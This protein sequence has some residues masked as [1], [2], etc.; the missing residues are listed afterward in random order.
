[1]TRRRRSSVRLGQLVSER[2]HRTTMSKPRQ[3]QHWRPPPISRTSLCPPESNNTIWD[4]VRGLPRCLLTLSHFTVTPVADGAALCSADWFDRQQA[5][6]EAIAALPLNAPLHVKGVARGFDHGRGMLDEVSISFTLTLQV[7]A[8]EVR[9]R[10]IAAS[11]TAVPQLGQVHD[12]SA[13]LSTSF[14]LLSNLAIPL[15]ATLTMTDGRQRETADRLRPQELDRGEAVIV[16]EAAADFTLLSPSPLHLFD[17]LAFHRQRVMSASSESGTRLIQESFSNNSVFPAFLSHSPTVRL[18]SCVLCCSP[19]CSPQPVTFEVGVQSEASMQMRGFHIEQPRL[20]FLLNSGGC[21]VEGAVIEGRAKA[22]YTVAGSEATVE[23]C[24]DVS[25]DKLNGGGSLVVRGDCLNVMRMGDILTANITTNIFQPALSSSASSPSAQSWLRPS[26]RSSHT[27]LPWTLESLLARQLPWLRPQEPPTLPSSM[28]GKQRAALSQDFNSLRIPY[29]L[30][31]HR[32]NE[33]AYRNLTLGLEDSSSQSVLL[34]TYHP[35]HGHATMIDFRLRPCLQFCYS[36]PGYTG[37][38]DITTLGRMPFAQL[39]RLINVPA[40]LAPPALLDRVQFSS[41]AAALLV[42]HTTGVALCIAGVAD[43]GPCTRDELLFY[44]RLAPAAPRTENTVTVGPLAA[45]GNGLLCS[46]INCWLRL[47]CRPLLDPAVFPQLATLTAGRCLEPLYQYVLCE[48]EGG[49]EASEEQRAAFEKAH[50]RVA[51]HQQYNSFYPLKARPTNAVFA[52]Q[53]HSPSGY[54]ELPTSALTPPAKH[55]SSHHPLATTSSSTSLYLSSSTSS[56]SSSLLVR[57]AERFTHLL[58]QCADYLDTNSLLYGLLPAVHSLPAA[59]AA[60]TSSSYGRRVLLSRYGAWSDAAL[61]SG[62]LL[63]KWRQ[64]AFHKQKAEVMNEYESFPL[65]EE[66]IRKLCEQLDRK[67]ETANKREVHWAAI[68]DLQS[69]INRFLIRLMKQRKE[70]ILPQLNQRPSTSVGRVDVSAGTARPVYTTVPDAAMALLMCVPPFHSLP[71]RVNSSSI[72]TADECTLEEGDTAN[73]AS[74]H[75]VDFASFMCW[76]EVSD[77]ACVY[78]LYMGPVYVYE[79][80]HTAGKGCEVGMAELAGRKDAGDQPLLKKLKQGRAVRQLLIDD[81]NQLPVT[82]RMPY[83]GTPGITVFSP[84]LAA[85]FN[86]KGVTKT[87]E[88]QRAKWRA[89]ALKHAKEANKGAESAQQQDSKSEAEEASKTD[90]QANKEKEQQGA[91]LE[92]VKPLMQALFVPLH[93][94][95]WEQPTWTEWSS[96]SAE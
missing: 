18:L 12:S 48:T 5:L 41:V 39:L 43:C 8:D 84:T 38:P 27:T 68:V 22:I 25:I 54:L 96:G 85:F 57:M 34:S 19:W 56:V 42:P 94:A 3:Q 70:H 92:Y 14:S 72:T 78:S 88:K 36:R 61:W 9:A 55:A 62:E 30:S 76:A 60:L 83:A 23:C 77:G 91:L 6:D 63:S 66:T 20:R 71:T 15:S 7:A 2:S 69:R 29:E 49:V 10:F 81:V 46:P 82:R 59:K 17:L 24:T 90:K 74:P 13:R 51:Q 21:Y 80:E 47:Q 28:S 44:N 31:E 86:A 33:V 11:N 50:H 73:N 40:G 16:F 1:M 58:L 87:L 75:H 52:L 65:A 4:V 95:M 37:K 26:E 89:V 64:V 79:N 45:D 53:P 67:Q 32:F 35:R 93:D